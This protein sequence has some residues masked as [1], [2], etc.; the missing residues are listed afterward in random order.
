MIAPGSLDAR[1]LPKSWPS[2]IR[3]AT[4]T[5][6]A[7]RANPL[8]KS[9]VEA[10]IIQKVADS[11]IG[12]TEHVAVQYVQKHLGDKGLET[13]RH[14]IKE[15]S[16][17]AREWVEL[18]DGPAWKISP[19]TVSLT[20]AHDLQQLVT[21]APH[22][23]LISD[24]LVDAMTGAGDRNV[25]VSLPS[26]YGKSE[27]AGRRA[28]LW[29]LSNYP[30]YPC[31]YVSAT[32]ELSNTMGRLIK[33][34]LRLHEARCGFSLAEDSSASSRFNTSIEGGLLIATG[35]LGQVAGRG[36]AMLVIDD[37]S[38]NSEQG[39]SPTYQRQ[40]WELWQTTLQSRLQ[41]GAITSVIGTRYDSKDF[42]G[43][44]VGG[45]EDVAPLKAR[46]ISLPALAT[47][48]DELGRA[49]GEPLPLGPVRVDG[50]GYTKEEL[51]AR[52]ANT[53][54]EAWLTCYQQMPLDAT[55]V[56]KAF[57]FDEAEHVDE[58]AV[59]NEDIPAVRVSVDFNVDGFSLVFGQVTE[60]IPDH[61]RRILTNERHFELVIFDEVQLMNTTTVGACEIA[62]EKIRNLPSSW[63]TRKVILTGDASG[64][65]RRTSSGVGQVPRSDWDIIGSEFSRSG[66]TFTI[67]KY[68]S[69]EAVRDKVNRLN[70]MLKSA[71][72]RPAIRIHP[73]CKALIR[74]LRLV[75]WAS[76]AS[77]NRLPVLDKRDSTLGHVADAFCYMTR[78]VA[79]SGSY[80]P[81]P[82]AVPGTY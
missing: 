62:I 82:Y 69:N 8:L 47:G 70:A 64:T 27:T 9:F 79:T 73:K 1:E 23:R 41:A 16:Q 65:Q 59:F 34:D 29:L 32:D 74:D 56:G 6:R 40:V 11:D 53:S 26:R 55:M 39:T 19:L 45:H 38:K 28:L 68:G 67:Q 25:V 50:F 18:A 33:T 31:I 58:G 7:I 52:K 78:A 22:I 10:L 54:Q 76:D 71:A 46:V 57:V 66:L 63:Q 17:E 15:A 51:L 24:A 44:L 5:A 13:Y 61:M 21:P 37:S 2:D 14:K 20:L 80:G 81:Q 49:A 42:I 12:F 35:V 43:R 4:E 48:P 77:G 75:R 72:G 60:L 3:A 36:A 30:G